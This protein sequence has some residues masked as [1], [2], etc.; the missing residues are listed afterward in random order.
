MRY[1]KFLSRRLAKTFTED[2]V[3]DNIITIPF[4]NNVY[5]LHTLYK[6]LCIQVIELI[7]NNILTI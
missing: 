1:N 2:E 3:Y 7:N 6:L 4:L 5:I